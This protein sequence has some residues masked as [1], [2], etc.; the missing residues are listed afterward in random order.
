MLLD[1]TWVLVILIIWLVFLSFFHFRSVM[2]YRKLTEGVEKK[3]LKTLLEEILKEIKLKDEE[4]VNLEKAVG[5]LEKNS[6]KHIQ[7]FGFMRYNPFKDTGGDQSFVLAMLD[8]KDNGVVFSSFH[9]RE[10]T[11]IYA[12]SIKEG[13]GENFA[14]SEEEIKIINQAKARR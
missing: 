1:L 8:G 9:G 5:V 10:G 11:R 7:K 13:K 2:H 3:D 12:K 14:L 4:I 6:I